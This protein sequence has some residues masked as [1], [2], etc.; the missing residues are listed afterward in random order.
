M[1]GCHKCRITQLWPL[2]AVKKTRRGKRTQ[3]VLMDRFCAFSFV[4]GDFIYLVLFYPETLKLSV[5]FWFC[6]CINNLFK[7]ILFFKDGNGMLTLHWLIS[8][9]IFFLPALA[10]SI[11]VKIRTPML[12]LRMIPLFEINVCRTLYIIQHHR[13]KRIDHSLPLYLTIL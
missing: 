12:T 6:R 8:K 1:A 9:P 11:L 7:I 2:A 4:L 5:L 13:L 3:I 10:C